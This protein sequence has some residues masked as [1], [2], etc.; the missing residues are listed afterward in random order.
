MPSACS[1]ELFQEMA[2]K[3]VSLEFL[4]TLWMLPPQARDQMRVREVSQVESGMCTSGGDINCVSSMFVF[5]LKE[6]A[7]NTYDK[8]ANLSLPSRTRRYG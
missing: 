3:L 4:H 7:E 1:P 2:Q 6:W 8:N 5:E